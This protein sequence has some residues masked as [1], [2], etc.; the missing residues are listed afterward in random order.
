[1]VGLARFESPPRGL[2]HFAHSTTK[3]SARY[4]CLLTNLFKKQKTVVFTTV[5][6]FLVG[7]ARFELAHGRVKVYCLTAWLQ[8]NINLIS[9]Y[10]TILEKIWGG[11][12]D[13]NP[14]S[15]V[16]QTGALTTTLHPPSLWLFCEH[17]L[18]FNMIL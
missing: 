8:P 11:R 15:P 1:M 10:L 6:C 12:W 18:Y 13:L 16:P 5:F 2:P 9:I 14:R 7:L 4:F 17:S 3:P